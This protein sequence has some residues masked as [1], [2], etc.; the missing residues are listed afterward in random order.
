M[1]SLSKCFNHNGFLFFLMLIITFLLIFVQNRKLS[2]DCLKCDKNQ[3][4]SFF[5]RIERSNNSPASY[6]FGTIHAPYTKVWSYVSPKVKSA[7]RNS[8]NVVFELDLMNADTLLSL[9]RCQLL[10]IGI[11]LSDIVPIDLYH[12]LQRH[13]KYVR[14]KMPSWITTEQKSRGL[15]ASGLFNAITLHWERKRP[16]WVMIML[17]SLTEN[18]IKSKGITVLDSFFYQKAKKLNKSIGSVE[19]AEEQCVTLNYLNTTQVLYALNQTLIQHESIR[20][21]IKRSNHTTDEMIKHYNCGNLNEALFKEDSAN[22]PLLKNQTIL[23]EPHQIE[24]AKNIENYFRFEIILKRNKRMSQR[25]LNLIHSRPK[26]SFFFVFGAGHFLGNDSIIELMKESGFTIVHMNDSHIKNPLICDIEITNDYHRSSKQSIV[27]GSSS[28]TLI[29]NS[30]NRPLYSLQRLLPSLNSP[31]ISDY[32][33]DS[34]KNSPRFWLPV[35]Q[36]DSYV[37]PQQTSPSLF[38][39]SSNETNFNF[40]FYPNQP[41]F[42]KWK[43]MQMFAKHYHHNHNL[44]KKSDDFQSFYRHLILK[45][46]SL[47]NPSIRS[48]LSVPIFSNIHRNN[49]DIN[50]QNIGFGGNGGGTASVFGQSGSHLSV[51]LNNH[52]QQRQHFYPDNSRQTKNI[53][54]VFGNHHRFHNDNDRMSILFAGYSSNPLEISSKIS[55]PSLNHSFDLRQIQSSSSS[56]TAVLIEFTAY[57]IRFGW[58]WLLILF[59]SS[60]YSSSNS[61]P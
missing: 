14:Y 51:P 43:L 47:S 38:Y 15:S 12:R 3:P 2:R 57:W 31:D 24:I 49:I 6:F 22:I 16:I 11:R 32:Y 36:L 35:I 10:P 20:A 13:L 59:I 53:G 37:K 7:F 28:K 4:F 29:D 50:N 26:E 48:S 42:L 58:C 54:S 34:A 39:P 1:F 56:T 27:D 23:E 19:N 17:N 9:T 40:N 30:S 60:R 45:D 21:G 8:D 46:L 5:W 18:D 25:V 55:S 52:H 41:L 61:I 33:E 44:S